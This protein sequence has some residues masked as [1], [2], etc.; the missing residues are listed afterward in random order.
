[1]ELIINQNSVSKSAPGYFSV[2]ISILE[3]SANGFEN[4]AK[5]ILT[6]KKAIPERHMSM[7]TTEC[8]HVTQTQKIAKCCKLINNF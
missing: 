2:G 6:N 1:M 3:T 7:Q 4:I 5:K 8:C